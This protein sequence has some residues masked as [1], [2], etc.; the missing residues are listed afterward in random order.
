VGEGGACRFFGDD[1]GEYERGLR[2]EAVE[3]EGDM[4]E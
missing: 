4:G 2:D 3:R 1:G